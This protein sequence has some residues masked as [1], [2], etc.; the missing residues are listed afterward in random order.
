MLE[1]DNLFRKFCWENW[2]ATGR[3]MKY[4]TSPTTHPT[5]LKKKKSTD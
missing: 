3:R 5:T 1:K 4:G 2:I